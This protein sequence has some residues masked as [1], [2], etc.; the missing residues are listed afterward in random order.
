VRRRF[1]R[2]AASREAAARRQAARA[3]DGSPELLRVL[4]DQAFSRAAGAPLVP[5]NE[6]RVL[7]DAR[8]NYPA[9]E[10]ALAG[11]RRTIHLE[12]YIVHPDRVGRRFVDLLA[13]RARA[14]VR[15]RVLYDWFGSLRDPL[16]RVFRPLRAA[17]GEVRAF[18][19][20]R[21]GA[22][23]GLLWRN[24]RKLV[25]ADGAVAFV[26]GL[27]LGAAWEGDPARS[28]APWRDTGVE[29]RGPAVADAERAFAETW[30]MEGAGLPED[31][32][33]RR[34][35]IPP[36]GE[37]A[38]RMVPTGPATAN[39]FRVDL[40]VAALARRTLWLTD[41]YFI[42]TA[43]YLQAL[44]RA[45]RDGVDVRLLLPRASDVG[46]IAAASRTLYRPLLEAGVRV[47]EW[48]G[49]MM[50]AKTAVADGRWTRV[51]ST[52]LNLASWL[53]NWELDVTVE[54]EGV[55]RLME[56]HYRED[57]AHSVEIV[58]GGRRVALAAPPAHA[59]EAR[60]AGGS[61]LRLAREVTQLGRSLGSVVSGSRDVDSTES[62]PL[63][64]FGLGSLAL[65]AAGA[66][67]PWVLA[68]P[69]LL[70]LGS[71]GLYLVLR[72]LRLRWRRGTGRT[73]ES[74]GPFPPF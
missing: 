42:A 47:F 3:A 12:M 53:A 68:A 40:L 67:W 18:N 61:G 24:H 65:A 49:P 74:A 51:G 52:N 59:D 26:S 22:P 54:D 7:R 19:P 33:P 30:A 13:E 50:H 31:E 71:T 36:A 57:L 23:L 60:A 58:L 39:I 25:T 37:V 69:L 56:A 14:G 15:V 4:A 20:P 21:P 11:A 32:L 9:W 29:I 28:R 62:G 16:G 45:A 10:A 38:L 46:W 66:F 1:R 34:E 17:G 44:Q 48:D 72:A 55:A 5:G 73:D 41:A 6:V 2:G 27:C 43:T 35:A 8:E 70:A 64:A 63:L